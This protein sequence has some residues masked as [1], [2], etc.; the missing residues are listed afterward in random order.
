MPALWRN[1]K[2]WRERKN[3]MDCPKKLR[4]LY[5]KIG[6]AQK[7]VVTLMNEE[8]NLGTVEGTELRSFMID[9]RRFPNSTERWADGLR[10]I[11]DIL[12]IIYSNQFDKVL[13]PDNLNLKSRWFSKDPANQFPKDKSPYGIRNTGIFVNIH[14]ANETKKRIIERLAQLFECQIHLDYYKPE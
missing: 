7:Q 8:I 10:A 1:F 9:D 2:R 4:D 12:S 5:T 6:E 3:L 13:D 11:C 14:S